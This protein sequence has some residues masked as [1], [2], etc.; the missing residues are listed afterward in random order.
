M[1]PTVITGIHAFSL[2]CLLAIP[3]TASAQTIVEVGGGWNYPGTGPSGETYSHGWTARV[4]VGP[5]LASNFLLRIDGIMSQFVDSVQFYPPCPFPGCTHAYYNAQ[6]V[7]ILGVVANGILN[8]DHRGIFY[9]IGGAGAYDVNARDH[10]LHMGLSAGAG[11][12]VPVGPRLRAVAEA[13]WN[14][15]VGGTT[16]P[17]WFAPVTFGLRY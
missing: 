4:S 6:T 2:A 8:V 1:K 5:Q 15:L 9:L 17:S 16:G 11:I 3:A 7:N 13:R 12:A 14:G 10:D